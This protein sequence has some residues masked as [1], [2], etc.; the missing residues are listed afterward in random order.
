MRLMRSEC[1]E[2]HGKLQMSHYEEREDRIGGPCS[3]A[4]H[5][6]VN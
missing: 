5:Y 4:V 3:E 6:L 1:R 2:Y